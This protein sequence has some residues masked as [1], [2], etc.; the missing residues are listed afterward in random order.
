MRDHKAYHILSENHGLRFI[1]YW[2]NINI[3]RKGG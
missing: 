2:E 1:Y 3:K